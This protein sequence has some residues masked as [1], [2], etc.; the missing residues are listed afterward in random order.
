MFV[1][2]HKCNNNMKRTKKKRR[3]PENLALKG[4]IAMSGETVGY[5]ADKI[6]Y[7]R[8]V[9]SNTINGNYKGENIVPL[10]QQALKQHQKR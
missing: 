9:V 1:C 7:S 10:L 2:I 5:W 6:G 8:E 4:Q 3:Y